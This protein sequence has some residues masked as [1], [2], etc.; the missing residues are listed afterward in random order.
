VEG[1]LFQVAFR[2]DRARLTVFEPADLFELG[3]PA[4][5][6]PPPEA[7]ARLALRFRVPGATKCC[8]ADDRVFG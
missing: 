2:V 7:D 4:V 1:E 8:E 3:F 6:L 5:D